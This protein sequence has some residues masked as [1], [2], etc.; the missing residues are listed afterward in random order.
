MQPVERY[1][2]WKEEKVS[3]M[4]TSRFYKGSQR[5]L[6]GL[7]T[8]TRLL[9]YAACLVGIVFGILSFHWLVV[10]LSLLLWFVRYSV[11]AYV[12]NKTAGEMGDNRSYYF[13]LPVFD[14]IRPLQ[15]LKLKLYRLYRG[16]GD[17]MRR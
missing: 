14:I 7:E 2:D 4:A 11:Q 1:K 16:K 13:T 17:F 3:Y 8:G 9:F 15:T 6:L 5:W 10:G 12:I